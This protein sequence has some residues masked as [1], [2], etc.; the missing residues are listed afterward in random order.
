MRS[1]VL[2]PLDGDD[3][4]VDSL[5]GKYTVKSKFKSAGNMF[6]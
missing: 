3:G 4:R 6:S 2:G 1:P 5:I